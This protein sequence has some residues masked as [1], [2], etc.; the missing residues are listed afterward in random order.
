[1]DGGGNMKNCLEA[2]G[3][4]QEA[5]H[6]GQPVAT[7][8]YCRQVILDPSDIARLEFIDEGALHQRPMLAM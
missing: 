7:A 1:M 3:M 6:K 5:Q 4:Q 2:V 8:T